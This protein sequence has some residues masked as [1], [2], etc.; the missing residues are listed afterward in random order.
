MAD[1]RAET[2]D[3]LMERRVKER[4][5]I[6]GLE[7]S[8]KKRAVK[9]FKKMSKDLNMRLQIQKEKM[10]TSVRALE[11]QGNAADGTGAE[12]DKAIRESCVKDM[13]EVIGESSEI[14]KVLQISIEEGADQLSKSTYSS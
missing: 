2:N 4:S 3:Q 5:L 6:A 10:E 12:A 11:K 8:S 14:Q 13:V 1:F 9:E 7:A